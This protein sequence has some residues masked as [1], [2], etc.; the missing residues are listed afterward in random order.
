MPNRSRRS[1][2]SEEQFR[3]G[4]TLAVILMVICIVLPVSARAL[5][6]I[7]SADLSPDVAIMLGGAVAEDEDV[8]IDDLIAGTITA[9]DLGILPGSADVTAYHRLANG[10]RLFSLDTT[11]TLGAVSPTPADVVRYDGSIHS[12]ELDG[13]VYG[14]PLGASVDAITMSGSSLAVSFDVTV[15]LS[16]VTFEDEDLVLFD[17]GDFSML[18]DGSAAGI[19]PGL[20]LDGAHRFEENGHLALSFDGS[21]TIGGVDF[22]DEDVLEY[23]AGG[24]T[25]ELAW[26]GSLEHASWS[27]ADADAVHLVPE[28]DVLL[29]LAAGLGG[30]CALSARRRPKQGEAPTDRAR[31]SA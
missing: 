19:A 6:P 17:S 13:G 23:D 22:D 24:P 11:V 26:D 1:R 31:C 5:T 28:P 21:G 16:G 15:S 12:I 18:F 30:L 25:W 27:A 7:G 4:Q 14:V 2:S 8:A 29:A 10:D 20:D 9:D 3:A